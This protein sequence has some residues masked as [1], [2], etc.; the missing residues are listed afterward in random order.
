VT[1]R[2][3]LQAILGKM[4]R[5]ARDEWGRAPSAAAPGRC[6][7]APP[8]RAP[9]RARVPSRRP[10]PRSAARA[11]R[12]P[13]ADTGRAGARRSVWEVLDYGDVVVHLFTAEQR[14]YYDLVRARRPGARFLLPAL[15][16]VLPLVH[17][18][19]VS[20]WTASAGCLKCQ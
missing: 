4:E 12:S 2:P 13:P 1:S 6:G 7:R 19:L 14:E 9:R 10:R 16:A 15:C 3:Q 11:C 20:L 17:A 8:L 5:L 18:G